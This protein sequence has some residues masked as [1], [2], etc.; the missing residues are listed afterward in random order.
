MWEW[1]AHR[2]S[3]QH[4]S[5]RLLRGGARGIRRDAGRARD[6]YL[7]LDLRNLNA[8]LREPLL[9]DHAATS[10]VVTLGLCD[11]ER[12]EK[13]VDRGGDPD[14]SSARSHLRIRVLGQSFGE[15]RP[16][17]FPV[18]RFQWN[19]ASPWRQ[20]DKSRSVDA[21]ATGRAI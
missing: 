19:R 5:C 7:L 10:L 1:L 11:D 3:R 12:Q 8:E 4:V 13:R 14:A 21:N 9:C 2:P 17:P 20:I 16:S 18:D 6:V 15:N